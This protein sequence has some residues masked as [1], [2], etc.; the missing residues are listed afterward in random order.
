MFSLATVHC[1]V[2]IIMLFSSAEYTILEVLIVPI[3]YASLRFLVKAGGGNRASSHMPN[4]Q[5]QYSEQSH[6]RKLT[7]I[8]LQEHLTPEYQ[9]R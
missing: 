7:I 2:N 4:V 9:T 1:T 6:I 8:F 5:Y 3:G